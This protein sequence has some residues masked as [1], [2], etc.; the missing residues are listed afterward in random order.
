MSY[1]LNHEFIGVHILGEMYGINTQVLNSESIL[2]QALKDGILQCGAS[3]CGIQT[4]KFFPHGLTSVALLSESHASIHSY[5]ESNALFFDAF[6]CGLKCKP[7]RIVETLISYLKPKNVNVRTINRG[8][9]QEGAQPIITYN[10]QIEEQV[11]LR[12]I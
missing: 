1:L 9:N 11:H 6:T 7:I 2:E 12:R 5:P 8:Q 3:I 4:Q 10:N